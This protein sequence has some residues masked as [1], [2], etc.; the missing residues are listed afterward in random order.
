M[1]TAA[2]VDLIDFRLEEVE[3]AGEQILVQFGGSDA[4]GSYQGFFVVENFKVTCREVWAGEFPEF[5]QSTYFVAPL[6]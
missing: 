3:E 2:Y 1:P 5:R 6:P 4:G